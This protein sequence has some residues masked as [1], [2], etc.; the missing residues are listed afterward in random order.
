MAGKTRPRNDL[1]CVEWDVKL[2]QLDSLTTTYAL[3]VVNY[4]TVI[5]HADESQE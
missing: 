1:L 5:A 4:S 2:T 3:I